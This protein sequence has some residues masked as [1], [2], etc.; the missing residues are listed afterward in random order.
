VAAPFPT[1]IVKSVPL[2]LATKIEHP[3]QLTDETEPQWIVDEF[4]WPNMAQQLSLQAAD[5]MDR[6]LKGLTSVSSLAAKSV[7]VVGAD[8]GVGT[9]TTLLSLALRAIAAGLRPAIVDAHSANPSLAQ[10]LSVAVESGWEAVV[11]GQIPLGRALIES[12]ND[13]AVLLPLSAAV[14]WK[15]LNKTNLRSSL[16]WQILSTKY[17][18]SLFDAGSV[19]R[20]QEAVNLRALCDV[21][22][23]VGAYVV[24]DAR[25]TTPD[26]LITFSRRLKQAGVRVL[27]TIENFTG[28]ASLGDDVA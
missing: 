10:Q 14:P 26:E 11:A 8:S 18:V 1:A 23:L 24:C 15:A 20:E 28:T 19:E 7:A 22:N 27:G 6:W 9:S 4:V 12:V 21:A 16:P 25:C 17:D 2:S 3:P 5:Q 13:R